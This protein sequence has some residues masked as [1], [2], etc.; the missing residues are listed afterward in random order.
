MTNDELKKMA[1]EV[2][3]ATKGAPSLDQLMMALELAQLSAE[4]AEG[5]MR[6]HF[7]G[8]A[9][10]LG[11]EYTIALA[12]EMVKLLLP[13]RLETDAHP[14]VTLQRLVDATTKDAS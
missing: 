1:E 7:E 8:A 12:Y 14:T 6:A 13:F 9:N 3:D 4:S 5:K 11:K 2:D 10:V